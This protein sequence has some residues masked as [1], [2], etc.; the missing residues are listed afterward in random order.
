[1][2]I[3]GAIASKAQGIATHIERFL[4]PTSGLA[5]H[6]GSYSTTQNQG[7]MTQANWPMN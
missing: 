4:T 7:A 2:K 5:N 6:S 1:M 3:A